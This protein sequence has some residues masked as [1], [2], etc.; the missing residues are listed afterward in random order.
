MIPGI[1]G[2]QR[3]TIAVPDY[4]MI[5]AADGIATVTGI[6][7][8]IIGATGAA[9]GV[10]T[11]SGIGA[12]QIL[13]AAGPWTTSTLS[14]G[15][16]GFTMVQLVP[17]SAISNTGN[18]STRVTLRG[19]PSGA[20]NAQVLEAWLGVQATSGDSYD[21]AASP[22]PVQLTSNGSTSFTV[23]QGSDLALDWVNFTI[24]ASKAV[25]F[26]CYF[27]NASHDSI[28]RVALTN[29][30]KWEFAGNEAG[31]VNKT[32]GYTQI[33]NFIYF[34]RRIEVGTA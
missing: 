30:N 11:V 23:P 29:F 34:L 16:N 6:G 17:S 21:F 7:G 4:G 28:G 32:A 3:A 5:G 18:P 24:P 20:E 8:S 14:A 22:T 15:F 1:V 13:T 25:L 33:S 12:P 27:N 2:G 26:A 10:A 19:A 31:T 9:A